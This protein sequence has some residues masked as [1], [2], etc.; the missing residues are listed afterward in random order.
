M[1]GPSVWPIHA[2][3]NDDM[4]PASQVQRF[5][6]SRQGVSRALVWDRHDRLEAMVA[7][8]DDSR[9]SERSLRAEC[10]AALGIHLTPRR[11]E[12][13]AERRVAA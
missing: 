8:A 12:L 11:I 1:R 13:R 2:D 7:V 10:A 9:W 6:I 4:A 3:T 5:L